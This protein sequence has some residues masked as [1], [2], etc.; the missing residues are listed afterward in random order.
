M[1]SKLFAFGTRLNA[2]FVTTPT[3]DLSAPMKGPVGDRELSNGQNTKVVPKLYR[4]HFDFVYHGTDLDLREIRDFRDGR[5][6]SGPFLALH[7]RA[8]NGN[9]LP[10]SWSQPALAFGSRGNAA[11]DFY[12]N[13]FAFGAPLSATLN[14]P[15]VQPVAITGLAGAPLT[16]LCLASFSSTPPVVPASYLTRPCQSILVPPNYAP[17][18]TVWGSTNTGTSPALWYSLSN[19]PALTVA[20]GTALSPTLAGVTATPATSGV[21]RVLDLW[22][23]SNGSTTANDFTTF[24]AM[25]VRMAL[26]TALAQPTVF[27]FGRGQFPMMFSETS[28]PET[29]NMI[30]TTDAKSFY[31]I[32]GAME[33][34]SQP[35]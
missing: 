8:L 12:S 34:V 1:T 19:I 14:N 7:P 29:Q 2:M 35:W 16:G 24:G 22:I 21:W 10:R 18:I 32:D 26:G 9:L 5:Y 3:A 17:R 33:E 25:D 27:D 6:G 23:G 28:L 13:T 20:A 30:G 4:R 11:M 31:E 15:N